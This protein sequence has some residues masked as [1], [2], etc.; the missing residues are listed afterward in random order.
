MKGELGFGYQHTEFDDLRLASIDSP[1]VDGNLAWSP[2]RGTDVSIGLSTSVQPSTTAGESGYTAYQ[3]TSTLSQELRDDLTAKLTGGTIWRDYPSSSAFADE[4]EYDAALGFTWGINRYL[5]LT[6]NVGYQ[7]TSRK[8]G[9]DTTATS[10]GCRIDRQEVASP[11]AAR[12]GD[13]SCL[14]QRLDQCLEPVL[15]GRT[16]IRAGKSEGN[17]GED[18]AILG[19]TVES[20]ALEVIA[21]EILLLGEL[22]HAVRQLDLITR[23]TLLAFQ[24]MENL[25]LQDVAAVDEEVRGSRAL[26]WLSTISVMRKPLPIVSPTPTMPYLWVWSGAHSSTAMTLPPLCS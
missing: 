18:E 26:G 10:G 12:E 14:L 6:S 22:Q 11:P 1:T 13:D 23:T 20:L 5:D 3:L 4:T 24:D 2:Q 19:A 7:L 21:G 25:R 9:D 17:V 16:D 8:T 15:D